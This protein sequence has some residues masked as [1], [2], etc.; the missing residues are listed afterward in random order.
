MAKLLPNVPAFDGS[1]FNWTD[2][3]GCADVSDF[4]GPLVGRLYADAC[5]VGFVVI[6]SR[7]GRKVVFTQT[8]GPGE[9]TDGEV[10]SLEFSS[11]EGFRVT[12]FN[13]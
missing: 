3:H 6:S 10:G 5:D 1:K 13:D 12:V 4:R 8:G 9:D 2:R 11:P 7:T